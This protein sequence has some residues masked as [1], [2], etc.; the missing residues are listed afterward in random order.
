MSSTSDDMKVDLQR[1]SATNVVNFLS[2]QSAVDSWSQSV[3]TQFNGQCDAAQGPVKAA[4]ETYQ[5]TLLQQG[6]KNKLQLSLIHD[7]HAVFEQSA[8]ATLD[9]LGSQQTVT[10][11]MQQGLRWQHVLDDRVAHHGVVLQQLEEARRAAYAVTAER[12]RA[13]DPARLQIGVPLMIKMIDYCQL[14]RYIFP[15]YGP[16]VDRPLC[17]LVVNGRFN[18]KYG[19]ATKLAAA[20]RGPDALFNLRSDAA[21]YVVNHESGGALNIGQGLSLM[22]LLGIKVYLEGATWPTAHTNPNCAYPV[23]GFRTKLRSPFQQ[24]HVDAAGN[25]SV[26]SYHL[27]DRDTTYA[28]SP[29]FSCHSCHDP[30]RA[31]ICPVSAAGVADLCK[32]EG[33]APWRDG[34]EY[35][36]TPF[37]QWEIRL[38]N[39]FGCTNLDNVTDIL[40]SMDLYGVD[41]NGATVPQALLTDDATYPDTLVA[42]PYEYFPRLCSGS[43]SLASGDASARSS[44]CTRAQI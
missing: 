38:D 22:R 33:Y 28:Y 15:N 16:I 18:L 31:D 12:G 29:S 19:T 4:C 25:S 8:Q 37:A 23:L 32:H 11:L 35:L 9:I 6:I 20:V 14:L 21:A 44:L 34:E 36:P 39:R 13:R 10:N 26:Q 3:H 7:L 5:G 43:A 17:G 27:T 2:A 41:E 42:K 1:G 24:W 30:E 40:L